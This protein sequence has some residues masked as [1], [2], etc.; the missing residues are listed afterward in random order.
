MKTY[1][2]FSLIILITILS[3][4]SKENKTDLVEDKVSSVPLQWPPEPVPLDS[5]S[6]IPDSLVGRLQFGSGDLGQGWGYVFS[7]P[8][9][10]LEDVI[11]WGPLVV[12]GYADLPFCIFTISK[13]SKGYAPNQYEVI[14]FDSSKTRIRLLHER[15]DFVC[16]CYECYDT[17]SLGV[18]ANSFT[19]ASTQV[20]YRGKYYQLKDDG[21]YIDDKLLHSFVS[22]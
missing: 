8:G 9:G 10:G 11:G 17:D 5:I 21:W 14:Y 19:T 2:L 3:N 18:I 7:K 16:I 15:R 6:S 13:P 22:N 20:I 12:N 4:C 1:Y